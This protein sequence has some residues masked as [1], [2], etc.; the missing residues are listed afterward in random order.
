M[1]QTTTTANAGIL[2]FAQ[3]DGVKTGNG[4]SISLR[5][6]KQKDKQQQ[7]RTTAKTKY[8]DPFDCAI[9]DETVNGSAQDDVCLWF[10]VCGLRF[11]VD[12]CGLGLWFRLEA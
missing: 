7:E 2:H 6:D 8:R 10:V 4:N 9:H 11:R 3:D 1:G 12:G 5:D